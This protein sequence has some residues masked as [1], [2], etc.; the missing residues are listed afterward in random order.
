[1]HEPAPVQVAIVGIGC[2]LQLVEERDGDVRYAIRTVFV[3][4]ETACEF[5]CGLIAPVVLVGA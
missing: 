2:R 3:G 5:E 1:M 4:M